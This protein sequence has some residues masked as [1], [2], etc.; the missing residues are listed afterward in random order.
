VLTGDFDLD[1]DP[2]IVAV[3][4]D[5]A[6]LY[7]NAGNASGTFA[8]HPQQLDVTA[9]RMAVAGIFGADERVDVAVI[10]DGVGV[11]YNDG[12][13]NF[14]LGDTAGPTI[15]L[16]GDATMTLVVGEAYSDA[17]ATAMDAVDGDV[18]SRIAVTNPVDTSVI[19]T[20]EV[21]YAATDLSGN[22]A[23][24]VKRTVRVQAHE[25]SQGGGGGALG[26]ELLAL[27][28]ALLAR[29]RG[30]AGPRP[31]GRERSP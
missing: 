25:N 5:G 3:N 13:G 10:G 12:T 11:F 14:G 8:L 18:T 31:L 29:R 15:S 21:T 4:G 6:Q 24:P 30:G 17:G 23:T 16:K 7:T 2:D 26:I 27:A 1:G 19:G 28:A 20:Y 22:P 9:A